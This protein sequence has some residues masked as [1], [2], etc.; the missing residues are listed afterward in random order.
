MQFFRMRIKSVGKK[1]FIVF[2]CL[3]QLFFDDIN[4][5]SESMG[6]FLWLGKIPSEIKILVPILYDNQMIFDVN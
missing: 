4:T 2:Y 5:L 1:Q 3:L 6:T